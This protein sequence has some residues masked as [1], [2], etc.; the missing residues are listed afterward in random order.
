MNIVRPKLLL[1][2]R[3]IAA[4]YVALLLPSEVGEWHV[5][6]PDVSGC[7]TRGFTIQDATIAAVSALARGAEELGRFPGPG[8]LLQIESEWKLAFG[9]RSIG[10]RPS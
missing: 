1:Q 5:L 10:P 3:K 6:F 9:K 7:E 2:R 4:H 8:S